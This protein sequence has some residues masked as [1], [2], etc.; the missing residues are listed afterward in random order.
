MLADALTESSVL[1][2]EMVEG[3]ESTSIL[4]VKNGN[5]TIGGYE[6]EGGYNGGGNNVNMANPEVSGHSA[7]S[8]A[9]F[10][11]SGINIC[12]RRGDTLAVVGPVGSGK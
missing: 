6:D 4:E 2:N 12:I 1:D 10:K 8:K 11:R 3:K 5:F 9:E 7:A